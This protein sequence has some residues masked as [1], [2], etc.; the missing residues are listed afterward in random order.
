MQETR[1]KINLFSQRCKVC[2]YNCNYNTVV[3]Y[4][5]I[6]YTV[7]LTKLLAEL[8]FLVKNDIISQKSIR[9]IQMRCLTGQN[10]RGCHRASLKCFCRSFQCYFSL[11]FS[12]AR[13]DFFFCF[14]ILSLNNSKTYIFNNDSGD[15]SKHNLVPILP[16]EFQEQSK[17]RT[18]SRTIQELKN[19]RVTILFV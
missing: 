12:L 13:Y 1:I 4:Y 7:T 19:T 18:I 16:R 8:L 3:V 11:F 15:C 14:T 5:F 2:N 10:P 6:Q 9:R 17:S